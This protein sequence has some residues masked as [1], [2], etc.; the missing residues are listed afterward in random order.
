MVTVSA[1]P[2]MLQHTHDPV[3]SLDHDNRRVPLA[4]VDE[5]HTWLRENRA[6]ELPWV[7]IDDL[8]LLAMNPRMQRKH[9]V[10]TRDGT[11]LTRQL[12]EDALLTLQVQR[13]QINPT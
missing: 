13:S 8:D 2:R 10:R 9:F 3:H 1:T 5:I 6:T 7:A 4:G 11:G 12:V